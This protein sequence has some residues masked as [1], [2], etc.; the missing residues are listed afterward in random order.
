VNTRYLLK[1]T[2]TAA[3]LDPKFVLAKRP[4]EKYNW[5]VLS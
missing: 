4:L 2:L 5:L 1:K 3:E